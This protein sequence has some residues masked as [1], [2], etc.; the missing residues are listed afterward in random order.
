MLI[1]LAEMVIF[2]KKFDFKEDSYF[3]NNLSVITF[4]I[5]VQLLV[6]GVFNFFLNHKIFQTIV[7]LQIIKY[8]NSQF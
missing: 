5:F 1:F 3:W 8:L 2:N 6:M 7:I 4:T